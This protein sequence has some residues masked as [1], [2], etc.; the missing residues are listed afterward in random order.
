MATP[1][2]YEE[3]KRYLARALLNAPESELRK[4][5]GFGDKQSNLCVKLRDEY[6]DKKDEKENLW[7]N[8]LKRLSKAKILKIL[9]RRSNP[10]NWQLLAEM[11]AETQSLERTASA[12]L[13]DEDE[14]G[15]QVIPPGLETLETDCREEEESVRR[16]H[17]AQ[18]TSPVRPNNNCY[19]SVAANHVP[20]VATVPQF[21]QFYQQEVPRVT[22][23]PTLH[24]M[25][26][27]RT[28]ST[29]SPMM[30]AMLNGQVGG[31]AM[32]QCGMQHKR[33]LVDCHIGKLMQGSAFRRVYVPAVGVDQGT[34]SSS[35]T[36]SR[37]HSPPSPPSL[38]DEV[39]EEMSQLSL[40]DQQLVHDLVM[41]LRR[42]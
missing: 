1:A 25:S 28:P 37:S 16:D 34:K 18:P 11:V 24:G 27:M 23:N 42:Q 13:N 30:P 4:L 20:I 12:I 17:C 32:N 3:A 38:V 36:S 39:C 10:D 14:E 22:I 33:D 5:W 35:P 15:W 29:V 26:R 9:D 41:R 19:A 8:E 6:R 7:Q 2:T 40:K 21:E 31:C